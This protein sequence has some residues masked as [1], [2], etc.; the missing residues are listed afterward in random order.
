MNKSSNLNQYRG[1]NLA[2]HKVWVNV[3]VYDWDMVTYM[4]KVYCDNTCI[5][6]GNVFSKESDAEQEGLKAA[7]LH[8]VC[9]NPKL[10]QRLIIEN[11]QLKKDLR[12]LSEK[13]YNA[14]KVKLN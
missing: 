9:L 3:E 10:A 1:V 7:Y 5:F 12:E 2:D 8:I 11:D 13:Y 6:T 14:I 4:C